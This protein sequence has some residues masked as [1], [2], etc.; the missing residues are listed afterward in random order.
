[1]CPKCENFA[2]FHT[3]QDQNELDLTNI[4]LTN[5]RKIL[6][7]SLSRLHRDVR[8]DLSIL[9]NLSVEHNE[10]IIPGNFN[11]NLVCN[12]TL[13]DPMRWL[14]LFSVITLIPTHCHRWTNSLIFLV[15]VNNLS[16][17]MLYEQIL[18]S[19]FS[20]HDYNFETMIITWIMN[21]TFCY[22][23]WKI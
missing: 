14:G 1:M 12:V 15:F 18:A 11:N 19:V 7:G 17:V 10:M 16:K 6:N 8:I 3:R 20:N 2:C 21:L 5:K 13:I 22:N 9:E 23:C 4:I